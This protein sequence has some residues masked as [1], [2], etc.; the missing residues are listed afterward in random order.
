MNNYEEM[1]SEFEINQELRDQ[2]IKLSSRKYPF[3]SEE[4]IAI[5]STE[6]SDNDLKHLGYNSNLSSDQNG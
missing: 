5:L 4:Q 1:Y 2:L 3:L 6:A